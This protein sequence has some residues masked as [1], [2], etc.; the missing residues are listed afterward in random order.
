MD[1]NIEIIKFAFSN[2]ELFENSIKI[3]QL[4]FCDEQK[5]SREE[6]FDGLDNIS[7]QY[8]LKYNNKFVVTARKRETS[9]GIKL[10]R[11][12]V[13]KEYRGLGLAS[14][15]L[16]FMLNEIK[17]TEK[18]IYLNAQINAMPLYSKFGF[19]KV[20]EKFIEADILHYRME[21]K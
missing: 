14:K 12:A 1:N 17:D 15:I 8:L 3:R 18:T 20:G 10:E 4:V 6:E 5:V 9:E 21:L 2:K 16:A 19:K 11:F 7:E 13:L